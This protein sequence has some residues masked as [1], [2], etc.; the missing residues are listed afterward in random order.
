MRDGEF[1][2]AVDLRAQP[3]EARI[4]MASLIDRDWLQPNGIEIVHT[5]DAGA[6]S[7][8]RSNVNATMP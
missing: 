7:S 2:V 6:G 5:F 1:L 8:G 4:G 3:G